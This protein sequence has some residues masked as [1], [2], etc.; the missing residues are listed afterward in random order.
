MASCECHLLRSMC[1]YLCAYV[2]SKSN[3]DSKHLNNEAFLMRK[4]SVK[5]IEIFSLKTFSISFLFQFENFFWKKKIY[6]KC[7]FHVHVCEAH[8]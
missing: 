2:D 3:F 5:F 4:Y 8:V 7:R 6:I 1:M